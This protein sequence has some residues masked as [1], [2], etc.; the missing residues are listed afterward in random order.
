MKEKSPSLIRRAFFLLLITN[1]HLDKFDMIEG[2][3]SFQL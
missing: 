1:E 2:I 3:H